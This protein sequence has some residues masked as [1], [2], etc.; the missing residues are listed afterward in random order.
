M[1]SE[2]ERKTGRGREQRRQDKQKERHIKMKGGE[3]P[4]P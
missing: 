1:S 3:A 2:E 4:I